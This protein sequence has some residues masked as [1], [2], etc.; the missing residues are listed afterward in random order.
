[1][2]TPCVLRT[3]SV[4]IILELVRNNDFKLHLMCKE[5]EYAFQYDA[6][7]TH[8]RSW[9]S[10]AVEEITSSGPVLPPSA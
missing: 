3:R 7:V 8:D 6:Q 4:G 10:T 2:V 9:R 1:M 5:S